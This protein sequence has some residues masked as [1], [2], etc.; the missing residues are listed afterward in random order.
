M[1]I[2]SCVVLFNVLDLLSVELYAKII[3]KNNDNTYESTYTKK[4]IGDLTIFCLCE[5]SE[6]ISS[7]IFHIKLVLRNPHS[8]PFTLV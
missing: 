7:C 4:V 6:A 2:Q 3:D 8:T 1:C 5:Q